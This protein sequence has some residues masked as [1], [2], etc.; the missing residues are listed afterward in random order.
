MARLI[1]SLKKL[2]AKLTGKKIEGTKLIEVIEE[3]TDK[4][5]GVG[6]HITSDTLDVTREGENCDIEIPGKYRK[7]FLHKLTITLGFSRYD[8]ETGEETEVECGTVEAYAVIDTDAKITIDNIENYNKFI[9]IPTQL[10]EIRTDGDMFDDTIYSGV[11]TSD[12]EVQ[13]AFVN[14][15]KFEFFSTE[16][17]GIFIMNVSDSF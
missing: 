1:N 13:F 14:A 10:V 7:T 16:L 2:G 8:E 17:M 5:G 9:V 12:N 15:R 4:Y 11:I 3:T 6:D